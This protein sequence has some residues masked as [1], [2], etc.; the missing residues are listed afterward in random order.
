MWEKRQRVSRKPDGGSFA[1]DVVF[2]VE[3]GRVVSLKC[4]H[5]IEGKA[6]I[7]FGEEPTVTWNASAIF[8]S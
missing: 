3:I 2:D 5:V 7:E 6:A 1:V 4:S 8:C